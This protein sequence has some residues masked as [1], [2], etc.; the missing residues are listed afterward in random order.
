MCN[1][2]ELDEDYITKTEDVLQTY[3]QPYNPKQLV[4]V[5]CLDEKPFTLH[6]EVRPA[7]SAKPGRRLG[8]TPLLTPATLRLA[9]ID[10]KPFHLRD[11]SRPQHAQSGGCAIRAAD[12]TLCLLESLKDV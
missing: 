9:A 11:Q 6:A 2:R 5:V 12:H 10:T 3:E 1:V 8:L 7:S 4:V